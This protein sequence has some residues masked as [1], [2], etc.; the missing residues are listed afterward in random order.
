MRADLHERAADRHPGAED[1]ARYGSGRDARGGLARR[2]A[3]AAAVVADSVFFPI[4]VI[5][6]TRAKSIGNIAVIL[7]A[8]IGIFD[9]QLNRS[10]GRQSVEG[11]AHDAHQ[12]GFPPLS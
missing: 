9:Q 4:S 2:G 7:C 8:L 6:V 5:S 3:P 11:A 12:I 1:L 10:P